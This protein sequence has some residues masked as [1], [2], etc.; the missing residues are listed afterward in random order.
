MPNLTRLS[1]ELVQEPGDDLLRN[2][3][4]RLDR[5][6]RGP[7]NIHR[8]LAASPAIFETFINYAHAL[9]HQTDLEPQDREL[10]IVRLLSRLDARYELAHHYQMAVD[11]G[12]ADAV[13][14]TVTQGQIDIA[15][16]NKRQK[17]LVAFADRFITGD[18]LDEKT[19]AYMR[20]IYTD[21]Q[22]LEIGLTL[23]LYLGLAHLTHTID[24]PFE[25]E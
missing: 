10:L 15:I 19:A 9:R 25:T 16:L 11:A 17:M 6:G 1:L 3:F 4:K 14:A 21:R 24:V 8:L 12:L 5:G 22:L 2:M 13:L 18:G 7:A 20:A 23:A